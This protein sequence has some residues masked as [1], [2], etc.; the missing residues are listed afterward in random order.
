MSTAK[1]AKECYISTLADL[2]FNS[3]PLINVL[4]MLAEENIAHAPVIVE[5]I[6][7]HLIKGPVDVKLPALYLID[8]IIKNI[9]GIYKT[10]LS[11]NIVSIFCHVFQV[12]NERTRGEMFKL[13]QTWNEEL[14]KSKLCELD[15]KVKQLDP[16]WPIVMPQLTNNIHL[17]PKFLHNSAIPK[18]SPPITIPSQTQMSSIVTNRDLDTIEMQKNFIIKQKQLLEL[19]RMKLELELLQQQVKLQQQQQQPGIEAIPNQTTST[20][21]ETPKLSKSQNVLLKPEVAKQLA[22]TTAATIAKGKTS[23]ITAV[24]HK[25]LEAMAST[26]A[27]TTPRIAHTT[28]AETFS[29]NNKNLSSKVSVREHHRTTEPRLVKDNNVVVQHQNNANSSSN[30]SNKQLSQSPTKKSS[31]IGLK[32]FSAPSDCS[33]SPT[34]TSKSSRTGSK[35][36]SSFS[37]G[38]S[39]SGSSTNLLDSPSKKS[40]SGSGKSVESK[41]ARSLA[42]SSSK[43]K[44]KEISSSSG[45][46]LPA[47]SEKKKVSVKRFSGDKAEKES[48]LSS[49][50]LKRDNSPTTIFKEVKGSK[51]RN[52]IRRNRQPSLSPEPVSM[53]VDLRANAAP[54]EKQPRL[55][56]DIADAKVNLGPT[57]DLTTPAKDIDLRQLPAIISKK[58]P[59]TEL[60]EATLVKKSKMEVFDELFGNEDTDLRQL[61]TV[62]VSSPKIPDRP[63]TPPP[64]I[65]SS[66]SKNDLEDSQDVKIISPKSSKL[67]LVREKLA[68]ATIRNKM[69]SSKFSLAGEQRKSLKLKPLPSNEDVDLRANSEDSFNKII[70]SPADEQCIKTGN[71]TKEQETALMNKIL[72]QIESQKLKEA[73]RTEENTGNI[74]LQPISDDELEPDFSGSSDEDTANFRLNV[75]SDKDERVPPPA[76]HINSGDNFGNFPRSNIDVRR[77]MWRGGRPRRGIMPG[78]GMRMMRPPGPQENWIRPNGPWRPMVSG[79]GKPPPVFNPEAMDID[80]AN[81]NVDMFDQNSNQGMPPTQEMPEIMIIDCANQ[82]N[83]KSIVIDNESRDIRYYDDTAI[84]FMNCADPREISFQNGSRKVFFGEKDV[85]ILSFN[86]PYKDVSINGSLHKV[87]LGGPSRELHIDDKWYECFIG[88]PGIRIELNGEFILV[89]IEGPPP[90]VKIGQIKRTDLVA[91]KINLI[92]DAKTMVPVFLDGKLQKFDINGQT[93]TL[94]FINSL[95]MAL[96]DDNPFDIEFGGLPKPIIL[97]DKKYYIRFSVLPRGVKSGQVSIKGMDD[98]TLPVD[99]NEPALPVFNKRPSQRGGP[100]SPDRN[101]NSPLSIQNLLQQQNLSSNLETL[102]SLMASSLMPSQSSS[103]LNTSGYQVEN[104]VLLDSSSQNQQEMPLTS[105]P[106]TATNV[107]PSSLNIN[108]LFQKLVA[109]GI[110]TT[111]QDNQPALITSQSRVSLVPTIL[112]APTLQKKEPLPNI[113]PVTFS[114]PETLKLRQPALI[115]TLY[116]GMQCSSCGM[117]FPPEHSMQYSQHLDW[118]FRQNRK[119]KKNIRKA[120]SR[121]WYYSLSDWKNYEEIEDL[122][123]RGKLLYILFDFVMLF[124]LFNREELL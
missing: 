33:P 75:Y 115:T 65:I 71:M 57:T 56:V 98:I 50:P 70:I 88:G 74:S 22:N 51:S 15:V 7:S 19:E 123:E 10:L 84:V 109:T 34:K 54:P 97:H 116:S 62:V 80:N 25:S 24:G 122:E 85:T 89:K 111:A 86:E 38:S 94:K 52:Y 95:Q 36:S 28:T 83:I 73:K 4:T 35:S 2:T 114:K 103:N 105:A 69:N 20:S 113:K 26:V 49:T 18:K 32:Q 9:G 106:S 100:N 46:G 37:S 110:V 118:H 41:T 82:D 72:A 6:E 14:P 102:S 79:F 44:K 43:N 66:K 81:V 58:R 67:D 96:I 17:N 90:Q 47:R 30:R 63:P 92:V 107:L 48:K 3:K 11:Q 99:Q 76:P 119:G 104:D 39:C 45:T 124:L 60:S 112:R 13:R 59:S 21:E 55:Q 12:V 64:P 91:G 77:G 40:I 101:S 31:T 68:N 120:S 61:P 1:E 121:R 27:N 87:K 117:R 5:A 16:A 108:D 23:S 93:H 78:R 29:S 8:C 53:D 42:V